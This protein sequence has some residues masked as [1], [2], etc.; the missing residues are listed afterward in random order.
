MDL[1]DGITGYLGLQPYTFLSSQKSKSFLW[2]LKNS[3]GFVDHLCVAFYLSPKKDGLSVVKFGSYDKHG[4]SDPEQLKI[5][6][7]I[8]LDGWEVPAT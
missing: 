6:K 2:Q 8:G 3:I 4:M 5:F 7:T 1:A